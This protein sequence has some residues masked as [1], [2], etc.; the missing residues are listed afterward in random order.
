MVAVTGTD[1]AYGLRLTN[2]QIFRSMVYWVCQLFNIMHIILVSKIAAIT[3]YGEV[4]GWQTFLASVGQHEI[5]SSGI[6]I[7]RMPC[8]ENQL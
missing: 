8:Y 6:T 5:S 2:A 7:R 1:C 3:S 4:R